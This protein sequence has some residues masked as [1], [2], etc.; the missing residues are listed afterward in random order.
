MGS[1]AMAAAL[2][3]ATAVA[4]SAAAAPTLWSGNGHYYEYIRAGTSF[5]DALAA[6]EAASLPGYDGYL[7][8]LTSEA[9]NAFVFG[10]VAAANPSHYQTWAGGSD[11]ETEGV[12][13]WITG[14]EAGQ[15][16]WSGGAEVVGQ[17]HNWKRP[18]EPNNNGA[19]N[20]LSAFYFGDPRWND[21]SGAEASGG[22]VVEYGP[23]TNSGA[24]EPGT[25]AIMILG[26]GMAG[27]AVRRRRLSGAPAR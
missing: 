5:E 19:E 15:T 4:G 3:A 8:T 27:A 22:Y 21:L 16:F 9:E 1:K 7:V 18:T 20:G 23:A 6:A 12:W 11:R 13:K 25:W 10:L 17:Y 14:P 24:P 2:L 26:F